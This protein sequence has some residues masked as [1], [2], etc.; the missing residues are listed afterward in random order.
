MRNCATSPVCDMQDPLHN[1]PRPVLLIDGGLD[2][3]SHSEKV[4]SLFGLRR[5]MHAEDAPSQLKQVVEA[6]AL[7]ADE[8]A[9]ATARLA[10]PGD[11]D[12]FAWKHGKRTYEVAV[13]ARDDSRFWVLFEDVTDHAIS[14]EIL[15]NARRYLEQ[16]LGHIPLGVI[17]LNSELHISSMNRSNL[18]FVRQLGVDLHLID[19]IG[20]TLQEAIPGRVGTDWHAQA[21]RALT[22]QQA[23]QWVRQEHEGVGETLVLSTLANP[24]PDPQGAAGGVLFLVEDVTDKAELEEQ[25][26]RAEKLAT[27]GE[28]IVTLNHEINNPL[29]IISASAQMLRMRETGRDEKSL[30][31]LLVIEEQVRRIAQV[32][33]RLRAMDEMVTQEYVSGGAKMLD[34]WK[35]TEASDEEV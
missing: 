31:K 23:Q 5:S 2:V 11:E 24:L 25:L 29:S 35:E 18:A 4:F 16:I 21:Q 19:V 6:D 27:V 7:L 1:F 26:V 17:V 15:M 28:M 9:L 3:I 33:Q 12:S 14:E 32:T 13:R 34:V 10:H 22:S 30:E 20:T 8:L